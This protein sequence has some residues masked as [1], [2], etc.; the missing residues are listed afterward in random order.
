MAER[1][2]A[3]AVLALNL[4]KHNRGDHIAEE[5][6]NH[7]IQLCYY[8]RSIARRRDKR[9]EL[10]LSQG[11]LARYAREDRDARATIN[12]IASYYN[13]SLH[14]PEGPMEFRILWIAGIWCSIYHK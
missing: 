14:E 3:I 7:A 2:K 5:I 10:R 12:L 4:A 8:A 13:A 6:A 11:M 9:A 1:E